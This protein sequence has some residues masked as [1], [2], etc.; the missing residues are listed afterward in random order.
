MK[1]MKQC[2][3]RKQGICAKSSVTNFKKLNKLVNKYVR[4][5]NESDYLLQQQAP[6]GLLLKIQQKYSETIMR[7]NNNNDNNNN[8]NRNHSQKRT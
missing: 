8:N 6:K 3:N 5:K 4:S 1:E 2:L 7:V